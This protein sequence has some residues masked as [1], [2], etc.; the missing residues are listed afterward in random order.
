MTLF[1]KVWDW[2]KA[3]PLYAALIVA[4]VVFLVFAAVNGIGKSIEI[5]RQNKF[6]KQQAVNE[7]AV[8]DA[9]VERDAAI[10][11]ADIAEAMALLKAKEAADL[12]QMIDAK[13]GTIAKSAAE[14]EKAMAEARRDA[15]SCNGD[16]DCLCSKLRAVGIA[17]Q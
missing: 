10:K 6:D 13:G 2:V 14:L 1:E 12:K 8:K 3:H 15:G 4:A 17:C 5:Y 16:A 7:Q 11:R 9:K